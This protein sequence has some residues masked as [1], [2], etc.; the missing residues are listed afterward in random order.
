MSVVGPND[1]YWY[2]ITPALDVD[3][4]NYKLY[5][6]LVFDE[7]QSLEF[8]NCSMFITQFG[9]MFLLP[10]KLDMPV[11]LNNE[12]IQWKWFNLS[13]KHLIIMNGQLIGFMFT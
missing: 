2:A 4:N 5:L 12:T 11:T 10:S 9:T 3:T 7:E 6:K 13:E 1:I 8:S